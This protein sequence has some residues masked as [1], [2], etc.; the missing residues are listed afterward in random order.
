MNSADEKCTDDLERQTS[1]D[2]DEIWTVGSIRLDDSNGVSNFEI[3][4]EM[5]GDVTF[6]GRDEL[7]TTDLEGQTSIVDLD[8]W[9]I[10]S[11]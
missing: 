9:T 2:D 8:F 4:D 6:A 3:R 7:L 1:S 11:S 10:K 5:A